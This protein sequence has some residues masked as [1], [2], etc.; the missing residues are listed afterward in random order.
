MIDS[1]RLGEIELQEISCA[2]SLLI[3]RDTPWDKRCFEIDTKEILSISYDNQSELSDLIGK[4]EG[5][6][7]SKT[8]IY[9][10]CDAN[11]Q[12][13]KKV[14]IENSYYI[15]EVSLTMKLNKFQKVDFSRIYRNDFELGKTIS[16]SD[17]EQLQLIAFTNFKYSRFH[18]DPFVDIEQAKQR[19]YNWISD[20]VNQEK[21]I[22]VYRQ[23]DKIISFMFYDIE[24]SKVDLILGGSKEGY[25]L[26]TPYFWSSMLTNLQKNGIKNIEVLISAA[27]I[28]IFNL[29]IKL[30]FNVEK[31]SL[32]FHKIL[33]NHKS[34]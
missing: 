32:D 33:D 29:Y 23:K 25:G 12:P 5:A 9:F 16:D 21:E 10:R 11:D 28:V 14:M 15:A 7:Q 30:G 17:I 24:G 19:Y 8:L 3:Y 4:F 6:A 2:K 27:N 31:T 13:V 1:K 20:L 18:E 26:M 34:A 22:L